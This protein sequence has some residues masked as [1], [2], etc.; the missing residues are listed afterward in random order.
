MVAG[1]PDVFV[2]A[3]AVAACALVMAVR[4]GAAWLSHRRQREVLE[5]EPRCGSCGYIVAGRTS[6]VCPECGRDV[7]EHGL[8]TSRCRRVVGAFPLYVLLVLL[9]LPIAVGMG[10]AVAE[11]QPLLGW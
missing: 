2:Y 7:R 9:A 3:A 10:P 11:V 5:R 8:V 6:P 4:V 1:H